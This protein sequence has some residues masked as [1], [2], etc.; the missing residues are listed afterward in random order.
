MLSQ[1]AGLTILLVL[2]TMPFLRRR[3]Y[4]LFLRLHQALAV[5][6]AFCTIMHLL[7]TDWSR[8]I[9]MYAYGGVCG[10]LTLFQVGRIVYRNKQMGSPW[11]RLSIVNNHG[12]IG[13][14]V[15]ASRPLDIDAGQWIDVWVPSVSLLSSHPFTVTSWSPSP[16]RG[17]ELLI[18]KRNGFTEHLLRRSDDQAGQSFPLRALFSGP[19]GLSVPVWDFECVL[20]FASNFGIAAVLPYLKK[21]MHGRMERKSKT[22]RV[23]L[24]WHVDN[25]GR[26]PPTTR[27]PR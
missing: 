13:A 9:L 22:R 19:H 7:S 6:A 18:Q 4:E 15:W 10:A 5:G 25:I 11:P 14:T 26:Q 21:L 16:E 1:A 24:V 23:R 17:F 27:E 8:W 2:L 20:F 12:S 3:S